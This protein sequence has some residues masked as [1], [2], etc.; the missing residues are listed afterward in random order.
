VVGWLAFGPRGA[1]SARIAWLS[2]V[3]P[4]AWLGFTLIRGAVVG[5]YPYPF[6]DV[7]VLGYGEA[8]LNCVWVSLLLVGLAGGAVVVDRR[9]SSGGSQSPSSTAT[10]PAG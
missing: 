3:F 7:N 6:I 4:V 10:Y 1:I 5:F 8:A 9:L 2:L